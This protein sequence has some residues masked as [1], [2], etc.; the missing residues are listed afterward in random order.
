MHRRWLTRALIAL[1]LPALTVT[2][3][4][5]SA[6]AA[7]AAKVPTI[8]A[9]A[10]I[11]PHLE[12]GS[13]YESTGKVLGP[14]KKCK[15]GKPIKGASATSAS[16][17]PDYTSGNPDVFEITGKTPMVSV[18][19]MKFPT[20]KAAV[21]YLHGYGK[22]AK[23]CPAGGGGGGGGGGTGGMKCKTSMKKIAFHLGDE[24]WGYQYK[25]KC[26]KAGETTTSVFNSLFSRK[27][28][29]VVYA[30]LMSMDASAPSI[31]KSVDLTELAMK[32]VG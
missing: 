19:A 31:P 16:Y 30:N 12:G 22:T 3:A 17:S 9:V 5:S 23:D 7:A 24:R 32:V 25:M 15:P 27:G 6:T 28:K 2:A 26:T 29:F 10:G 21:A 20:K 8:E 13:A 18:T 11:Y 1:A 4:T 14:G